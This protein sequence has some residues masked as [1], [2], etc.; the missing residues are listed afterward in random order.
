MG[1]A[2]T[3]RFDRLL[4]DGL[5]ATVTFKHRRRLTKLGWAR[6]FEPSSPGVFAQGDPPPRQWILHRGD[7]RTDYQQDRDDAPVRD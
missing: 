7:D 6:V 5:E 4:G 3:G 2:L 1:N